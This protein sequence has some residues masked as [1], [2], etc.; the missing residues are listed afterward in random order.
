MNDYDIV[1]VRNLEVASVAK[2]VLFLTYVSPC[3][4][5]SIGFLLVPVG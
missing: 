2:I 4:G 5:L 3:L 1:R